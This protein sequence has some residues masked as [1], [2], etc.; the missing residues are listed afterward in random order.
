[1]EDTKPGPEVRP[2][3]VVG[4]LAFGGIVAAVMQTLVVPLIG[5]LP[6]ILDTSAS[7]ASWVVTATL[8]SAAVCTPIAGRLG[9]LYGKRRMLLVCTLP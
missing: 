8:L 3:R 5:D 9:D 2:G 7:N 6:R 4:V 1:M